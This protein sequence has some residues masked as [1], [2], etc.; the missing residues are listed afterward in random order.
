MTAQSPHPQRCETCSDKCD[1]GIS[2]IKCPMTIGDMDGEYPHDVVEG[3]TAIIGCASH[4]SIQITPE[5]H[6]G[7]ESLCNEYVYH[8]HESG[9][10]C[11]SG[12]ILE[13]RVIDC[14]KD[15]RIMQA[16]ADRRIEKVCNWIRDNDGVDEGTYRTDCGN[17]F[18]LINEDSPTE[19]GF[20]Y[21]CFCGSLLRGE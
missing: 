6:C 15:T 9:R 7:R 21:C 1:C 2:S 17:V 8:I 19:N 16:A 12:D 4:S 5:G 10:D 3:I 11:I 14:K 18:V 20:K 13:C